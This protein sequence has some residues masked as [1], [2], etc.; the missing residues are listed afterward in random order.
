MLEL[1]TSL[2]DSCSLKPRHQ[3]SPRQQSL[4][5]EKYKENPYPQHKEKAEIAVKL[6]VDIDKVTC[7]FKNQQEGRE[8]QTEPVE[9][10]GEKF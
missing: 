8:T 4:L 9:Q 6:G 2:S 1:V 3:F 7:W 5:A 10:D